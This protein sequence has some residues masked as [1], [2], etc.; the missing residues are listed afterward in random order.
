[1]AA[2]DLDDLSIYPTYDTEG[3]LA[4]IKELPMQVWDAWEAVKSL[5]LPDDYKDIDNVV[6]LG[7]GGSAIGGDLVRSLV[8]GESGTTACRTSSA[9]AA[10]SSSPAT[11]ATPRRRFPDSRPRSAPAPGR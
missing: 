8:Q 11:P 7:M 3:M 5:Q 2:I 10:S 4:R 9:I 6:I 1:M